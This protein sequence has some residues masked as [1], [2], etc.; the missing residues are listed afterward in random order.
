MNKERYE[1]FRAKLADKARDLGYIQLWWILAEFNDGHIWFIR[2]AYNPE[3]H[4]MAHICAAFQA[5]GIELRPLRSEE[6][7]WRPE[8]EIWVQADEVRPIL[9]WIDEAAESPGLLHMSASA[10]Y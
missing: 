9:A 8:D 5:C 6:D 7:Q 2:D 1:Y 4:E 3:A 10:A